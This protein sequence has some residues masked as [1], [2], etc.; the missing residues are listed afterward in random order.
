MAD[1][2]DDIKSRLEDAILEETLFRGEVTLVV[3]RVFLKES[4]EVLKRDFGF[5]SL[6]DL[7]GVDLGPG[8]DEEKVRFYVV[9]HLRNMENLNQ[10]RVKVGLKPGEKVPSVCGIWKG[11]NWMERE[12]YDMFG[13]E[14]Y[15]HPD[16]TRLY[17]PEEFPGHPLR[18]DYPT[19]GYDLEGASY[20]NGD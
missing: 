15:G 2:V 4:L 14:F 19:E 3:D 10:L 1:W 5:N 11:A 12:A 13:I 16:L 18:K 9:Y 17:L 7:C 6:V 20:G 8:P